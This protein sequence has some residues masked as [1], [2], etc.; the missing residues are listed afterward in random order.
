EIK[1][2]EASAS[3]H[4]VYKKRLEKSSIGYDATSQSVTWEVKYNFDEAIINDGFTLTDV[5]PKGMTL[6]KESILVRP[7]TILD[8]GTYTYGDPLT[9]NDDYTVKN[10]DDGS[11]T[12]K[13]NN[14][15][16][17]TLSLQYTTKVSGILDDNSIFKNEVNDGD[18]NT[19]NASHKVNQQ[20]VI[21]R[22]IGYN[23]ENNTV[24]WQIEVNNLRE[25]MHNWLLTDSFSDITG[26]LLP[27]TLTMLDRD[28]GKNL[29]GTALPNINGDFVYEN[30]ASKG[31][32]I[33]LLNGYATTNHSFLITFTVQ[34]DGASLGDKIIN[35][36]TVDWYDDSDNNHKSTDTATITP[37]DEQFDNG[38]KSGVYNAVD[39]TITWNIAINYTHTGLQNAFLFDPIV[40]P[41][42]FVKGSLK[43]FHYS[44]NAAGEVIKGGT[45]NTRRNGRIYCH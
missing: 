13:S 5:I 41:Q 44:E 17:T 24:T 3:L 12:I 32:T 23:I 35:T 26:Q 37:T 39:K 2:L 45:S 7:V 10:N 22:A 15:L 11:I 36:A 33:Q 29:L 30:S 43:I 18:N 28:T 8:N 38:G 40:A 14:P 20:N 16:S 1:E 4:A 6:D 34:Y 19:T 21:K 31:F 25:N 9:I 27:D 42:N